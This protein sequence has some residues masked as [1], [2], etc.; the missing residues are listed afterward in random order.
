MS[1][2]Q[3]TLHIINCP[4]EYSG[5]KHIEMNEDGGQIGRNPSCTVTLSDHNKYISGN[6]SLVTFYA[7]TYYLSD[8]ST[9]GTFINDNKIFKNQPIALHQ[10]DFIV[11]GRYEFSVSLENMVKNIDIAIDIDPSSTEDDPL[12][13]LDVSSTECVLGEQGIIEDLFIETKGNDINSDDPV[14][15]IDFSMEKSIGLLDDETPQKLVQPR[16]ERQIADDTE[17]VHSEFDMP[18][19]IPEDWMADSTANVMDEFKSEVAEPTIIPDVEITD[20]SVIPAPNV[21]EV[22]YEVERIEP[23]VNMKPYSEDSESI[24][25]FFKGVGIHDLELKDRT[26]QLL[27]QM[28]ACLRL[29]LDKMN[30]DLR[31]VSLFKDTTEDNSEKPSEDI[32][33]LMLSLNQQEVLSPLELLQQ[34]SDELDSHHTHYHQAVTSLVVGQAHQY[35]PVAFSETLTNKQPFL[36]KRR[37]WNE[38]VQHYRTQLNDDVY[39][40]DALLHEKIKEHYTTILKV[41]NA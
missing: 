40:S 9:N 37:V 35:D 12:S 26:P 11:M 14:T 2:I 30:K 25:A 33:R 31:T 36:T 19:M 7:G 16:I 29:C 39:S 15:H 17:S 27:N 34:V 23:Y 28:G 18:N 1:I 4:E 3:L 32:L 5:N 13:C 38:Y 22:A 6:H 8:T 24:E 21:E 10:D 41:E 20:L